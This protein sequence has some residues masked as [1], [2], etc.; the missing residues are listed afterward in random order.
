MGLDTQDRCNYE[1]LKK[2][3][4][5]IP[6]GSNLRTTIIPLRL[7]ILFCVQEFTYFFSFYSH[8]TFEIIFMSLKRKDPCICTKAYEQCY[9][10]VEKWWSSWITEHSTHQS[11]SWRK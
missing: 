11:I 7:E 5:T 1:T 10:L 8:Y 9:F 4:A 3:P 2:N 6:V